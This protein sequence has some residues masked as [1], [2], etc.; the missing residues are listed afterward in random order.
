MVYWEFRFQMMVF[1]SKSF[2]LVKVTR[3]NNKL[4]KAKCRDLAEKHPIYK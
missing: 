2:I 3:K 4:L 1:E